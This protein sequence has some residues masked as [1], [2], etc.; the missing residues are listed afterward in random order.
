MFRIG[1]PAAYDLDVVRLRGARLLDPHA[2]VDDDRADVDVLATFHHD[3]ATPASVAPGSYIAVDGD[4]ISPPFTAGLWLRLWRVPVNDELQWQ[5]AGLITDLDYPARC[6]FGLLIDHLA[7]VG[8]YLGD[9]G[10]FRHAWLAF[11]PSPIADH[12]GRWLHVAATVAGRRIGIHIGGVPAAEVEHAGPHPAASPGSRLRIGASAEGGLADDFLD[13][14]IA[15]PFVSRTILDE[16]A[17]ARVVADRGRSDLP[18]L[19]P[20]LLGYWP[21]DEERGARVRDASGAGR[22]GTVVNGGAWQIGGP[23][24]DAAGRDAAY[25]P[26]ADQD[27]GHG[28]RLSSDDLVD[29]EWAATDRWSVPADAPSGTYAAIVALRGAIGA[30][31][32]IPFVVVRRGPTRSDTAALLFATN[33]WFAYGRR[34]T[35]EVHVAGLDA[36]F[37]SSHADGR[38]FF[39]VATRAP[40]PRADPFAAESERAGRIPSYHL[41]RPERYAEAWLREQGFAFECIT[42]LDLDAEPELLHRF[43]AFIIAGHNEYWT[44]RMRAGLEAYLDGGG[45]VLSMSGNTLYW[46]ASYDP[47]T[48][49]IESRK[50][51]VDEQTR[52]LP[53][54]WWGERI[55]TDGRPGGTWRAVGEPGHLLLG[56]DY[57]GMIDD[58]TPTSFAPFTVVAPDHFLFRTPE[59]VPLGPDLLLGA[60]SLNGRLASGYEFD[61]TPDR[62]GFVAEPPDGLTV[63]ASARGQLNIEWDGRDPTHGGD[64]IHWDRPAGG[65][66]VAVGS[67]AFTGALPVDG[68]SA[69]FIRNVLTHFGVAREDVPRGGAP[70]VAPGERP[71]A[72]NASSARTRGQRVAD[73]K[74]SA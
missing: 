67:I 2:S 40:I 21:L 5:W 59:H 74:P 60:R 27:R 48:G 72:G 42:D 69:A 38:P 4:P 49:L 73:R 20:D 68:P 36:S 17:L 70:A 63:L 41:V 33:T 24:F 26:A 15:Q 31:L 64:V 8:F 61:A 22:H 32:A 52:W 39:H 13:A 45:R 65:E 18:G 71:Q 55:H 14:D 50:T 28:L 44:D 23:A 46:R 25:D 16:T 11:A 37:Y 9:G 47:A 35:D 58:G 56:L 43:R 66:V 29:C 7:R 6:R 51:A 1:A 54:R 34:P 62:L 30:P 3:S 12:I 53:P 19:V 10:D 57:Q